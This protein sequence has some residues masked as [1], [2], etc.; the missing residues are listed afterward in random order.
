MLSLKMHYHWT[1]I[2]WKQKFFVHHRTKKTI[3]RIYISFHFILLKY[4]FVHVLSHF[5][6]VWPFATLWTVACQA[7]LSMRF[8]R[9]EHRSGLSC[10]LPGDLPTPGIKLSCSS[11]IAGRFFAA[12]SAEK[13]ICVCVCVC[14]CIHKCLCIYIYMHTITY[15]Y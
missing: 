3:S 1:S 12:Y 9:Q 11:C 5:S 4:L 7:L 6:Y 15:I 14:M 10:P 2:F 13:P 8:S